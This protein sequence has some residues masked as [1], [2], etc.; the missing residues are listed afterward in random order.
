MRFETI[1]AFLGC[2]GFVLSMG[3]V[4][5]SDIEV[6]EIRNNIL[7]DICETQCASNGGIVEVLP[8]DNNKDWPGRCTCGNEL[9]VFVPEGLLK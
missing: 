4:L 3:L 5:E 7:Y 9:R 2:V 1:I 8:L 6:E